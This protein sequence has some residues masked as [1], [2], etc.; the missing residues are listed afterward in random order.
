MDADVKPMPPGEVAKLEF[1][2]L[3]VMGVQG[4]QHLELVNDRAAVAPLATGVIA[5][6]RLR[7]AYRTLP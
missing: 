4:P 2:T 7:V 3:A 1:E 5:H 6:L